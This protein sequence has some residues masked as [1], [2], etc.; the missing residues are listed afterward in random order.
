MTLFLPETAVILRSTQ[1]VV[2]AS[3]R[4]VSRNFG[5]YGQQEVSLSD[6]D[7][8]W[9][10]SVYPLSG[11][12]SP[13]SDC[14]YPSRN[15]VYPSTNCVSHF[16]NCV[17]RLSDCVYRYTDCVYPFASCFGYV[18]VCVAVSNARHRPL[19]AGSR[20]PVGGRLLGEVC[21]LRARV[22]ERR[23]QSPTSQTRS[24]VLRARCQ[25]GKDGAA[26]TD[27][28]DLSRRSFTRPAGGGV[29]FRADGLHARPLFTRFLPAH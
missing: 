29:L 9:L 16:T 3:P 22:R 20:R 10:N 25:T 2:A 8:P 23:L 6:C 12:V 7:Y 26:R 19:R 4:N 14:V 18:N 15:C 17:Y 24:A 1:S 21:F 13:L 11:C 5:S 27:N 28:D